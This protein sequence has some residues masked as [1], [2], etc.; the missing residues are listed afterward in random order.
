MRARA[1]AQR[2]RDSRAVVQVEKQ[3]PDH[4]AFV[5]SLKMLLRA[6]LEYVKKHHAD[7]LRFNPSGKPLP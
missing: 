5:T 1:C 7:G 3:G 2:G 4:E 6:L